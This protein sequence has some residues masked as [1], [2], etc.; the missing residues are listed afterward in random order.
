M[1]I[2]RFCELNNE[3]HGTCYYELYKG[4][5]NP[6]LPEFWRDDS[7]YIHDD[8]FYQYPELNK[9]IKNVIPTFDTYSETAVNKQEW[10]EIGKLLENS[11][12]DTRDFY[13]EINEWAEPVL[14]TH[15]VFTILGL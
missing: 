10:E 4:E 15:G 8:T 7:L 14:Q 5:W 1:I 12:Q 3:R 11:D 13:A 2:M 9:A 6:A